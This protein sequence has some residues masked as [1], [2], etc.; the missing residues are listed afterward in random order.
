MST[1]KPSFSRYN[2][3]LYTN[4]VPV[5][6]TGYK[7][8][9]SGDILFDFAFLVVPAYAEFVSDTNRTCLQQHINRS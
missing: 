3:Y 4:A 6:H 7:Q 8:P 2:Y 1:P 5:Y 9:T